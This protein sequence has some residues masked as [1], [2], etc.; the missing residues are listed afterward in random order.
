MSTYL[1][2]RLRTVALMVAAAIAVAALALP[3]LPVPTCYGDDGEQC[4]TEAEYADVLA[5]YD[6]LRSERSGGRFDALATCADTNGAPLTADQCATYLAERAALADACGAIS[7]Q[8]AYEHCEYV[9]LSA[10]RASN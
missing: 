3:H 5:R 1:G 10:I 4:L 7:E 9:T 2:M 6:V 8:N